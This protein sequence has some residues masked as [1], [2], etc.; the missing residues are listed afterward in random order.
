MRPE[1]TRRAYQGDITDFCTFIGIS[2]PEQFRA[3]TRGHVLAWRAAL[4]AAAPG[5]AESI[6]NYAA[7]QSILA[8]SCQCEL[9]STETGFLVALRGIEVTSLP[10][11]LHRTATR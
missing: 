6:H 8:E 10:Q 2:A 3:V 4:P 5:C 7:G 11:C 9:L 1:D